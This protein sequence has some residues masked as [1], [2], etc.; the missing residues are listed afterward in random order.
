MKKLFSLFILIGLIFTSCSKLE[1][2]TKEVEVSFKATMG[3]DSFKTVDPSTFDCTTDAATYAILIINNVEYVVDLLREDNIDLF[4]QTIKLP[5]LEMGEADYE[6]TSFLLFAPDIDNDGKDEI[7]LATP[8]SE[9][10]YGAYVTVPLPFN[11]G[12]EE[13]TKNEVAIQ[14]L[15]FTETEME[16]FGFSW[17]SFEYITVR[18]LCFFGDICVDTNDYVGSLYEDQRNHLQRD[19]PAIFRIDIYNNGTYLTSK[20]NSASDWLGEGAVLCVQYPD[21]EGTDNYKIKLSVLVR[22]GVDANGDNTFAYVLYRTWDFVDNNFPVTDIDIDGVI[23]FVIGDCVPDADLIL[24]DPI[25]TFS[26]EETAY[27]YDPYGKAICFIDIPEITNNNWGFS[28]GAYSPSENNYILNLYAGAGGCDIDKAYHV[29]DLT[30]TY[31]LSGIVTV[32]YKLY[33]GY[34]FG[35]IQLYIGDTNYQI[36]NESVA[37]GLF[38]YKVYEDGLSIYTFYLKKTFKKPIYLIAHADV[39]GN[40]Y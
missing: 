7:I 10:T 15:C 4:T 22:T 14:V 16:A 31:S 32:T 3:G 28:N 11:F 39:Y 25:P 9:A 18:E 2:P 36:D 29:G 17:F 23:D 27:A 6:L 34:T 33:Q 5:K 12:V 19:M 30:L 21:Y 8:M 1:V 13:Y 20:D 35:D 38:T 24:T 37:P 40:K 26:G